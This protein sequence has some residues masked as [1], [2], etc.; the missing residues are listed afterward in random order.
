MDTN[1]SI[2][3]RRRADTATVKLLPANR[4]L[5]RL[6]S[7]FSKPLQILM[8]VVAFILLIACANVA[9]LLLAR[10]G[11][12]Q[13]EIGLRLALGVTRRRLVQQ[14]LVES[15]ILSSIGGLMG[16][17]FAQ[18]AR[19]VLLRMVSTNG[20]P[21]PLQVGLDSRLLAFTTAVCAGT[22]VLFAMLNPAP[23]AGRTVLR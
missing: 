4:G 18:W 17:V 5:S 1:P 19:D 8:A 2:E 16:L 22:G 20:S 11:A 23:A 12:R 7:Q 9:N 13:R 14:L 21:L 6:R 3:Q 10:A 15:V